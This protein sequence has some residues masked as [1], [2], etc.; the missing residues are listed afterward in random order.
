MVSVSRIV[1]HWLSHGLGLVMIDVGLCS[2]LVLV[3]QDLGLV[4]IGLVFF[5]FV[6]VFSFK[7]GFPLAKL[8]S[9]FSQDWSCLGH[10]GISSRIVKLA[11]DLISVYLTF[12][13]NISI[14]QG[15]FPK[16]LKV[17]RIL[18]LRRIPPN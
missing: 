3:V 5:F 14:R 9:V 6:L 12:A 16:I 1:L 10:N 15:Y 7:V 13:I 17:T 4:M 8:W 11:P 2:F 18:P